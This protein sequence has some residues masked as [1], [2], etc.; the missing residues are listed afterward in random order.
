MFMGISQPLT[1]PLA[2][3]IGVGSSTRWGNRAGRCQEGLLGAVLRR[4]SHEGGLGA[5]PTKRFWL[6]R[7]AAGAVQSLAA[8][9]L[10]LSRVF[11]RRKAPS[12]ALTA[13][14]GGAGPPPFPLSF[15]LSTEG[16]PGGCEGDTEG[17]TG[18]PGAPQPRGRAGFWWCHTGGVRGVKC[19]HR[20]DQGAGSEG[21]GQRAAL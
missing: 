16:S 21:R 12:G 10:A 14:P 1:R 6:G 7:A 4:C 9:R 19:G 8:P 2:L 15:P 17:L 5:G 11:M 18:G 20:R 13:P 3:S